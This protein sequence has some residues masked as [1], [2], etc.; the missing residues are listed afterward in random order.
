MQ[1][2]EAIILAGGLGTRLQ[3]AVPD[4]PKCMAPVNG[5]PF[6]AFVIDLLR[7]QG[8]EQ[9]LFSLGYRSEAFI[10]FLSK[11][12]PESNYQVLIEKEP[13]GTGGAIQF[14]CQHARDEQVIAMNGDSIFKIDLASQAAFHLSH[15]ADCTISLKYLENFDRYGAVK[16]NDDNSVASFEEKR[17]YERGLING[18]VYF[19]NRHSFLAERLP[20]KFS[21][22]TEYLQAFHT[23]RRMYGFEQ[24]G[25]F[26]DIGIPEDYERAQKELTE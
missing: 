14:A 13:L 3:S 8:I 19:L 5:R 24:Q 6:I 7:K 2:T 23:K 11:Q 10:G 21:F 22:E 26:I 17:F 1:V 4:L 9:F 25:Y 12:L 18:G 20:E 15:D 16:L